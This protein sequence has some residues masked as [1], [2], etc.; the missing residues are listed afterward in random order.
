VQ[1]VLAGGGEMGALTRQLDWSS[2]PLGPVHTWPQSLRSVTSV[3]LNS[4]F[5]ILIWWGPQYVM[6]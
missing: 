5:P 6:I 3:C 1:E 2:T 4:R